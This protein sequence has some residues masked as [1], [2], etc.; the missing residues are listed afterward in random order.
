[1]RFI[2]LMLLAIVSSG[3]AA[4]EWVKVGKSADDG[5]DYYAD[6]ATI[7]REG[8]MANLWVVYDYKTPQPIYE[9]R[10]LSSKLQFEYNC[11]DKRGRVLSS[12]VHSENMG[13][14]DTVATVNVPAAEGEPVS[15]G[16]IQEGILKIACGTEW[17][18]IALAAGYIFDIYADAATISRAG[19]MVKMWGIFDYKIPQVMPGDKRY[20]SQKTHNEYDCKDERMR[21]LFFLRHPA[22]MGKGSPV[23]SSDGIPGNWT[24]AAAGNIQK[25]FFKVACGK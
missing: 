11:K 20:L 16:S 6:P 17:V 4:A 22:N 7:R 23:H 19:D 1:M 13:N 24:S 10:F 14:G 5:F 15:P 2:L 18:K 8:D 25:G 3:A 21:T 12:T 9:K